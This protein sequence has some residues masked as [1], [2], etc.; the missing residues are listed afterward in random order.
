MLNKKGDNA[1]MD[2]DDAQYMLTPNTEEKYKKINEDYAKALSGETSLN[3]VSL[4]I[5]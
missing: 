2:D 1:E 4:S 5:E 3:M